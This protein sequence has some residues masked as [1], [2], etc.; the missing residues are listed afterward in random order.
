MS[1]ERARKN[2]LQAVEMLRTFLMRMNFDPKE[3]TF[4]EGS[5]FRMTMEGPTPT[6]I[7]RILAN[8]ERFT[9]H[10]YFD[11]KAAPELRMKVAEF[12]TRVN[13]GLISGSL[14]MSFSD[15]MLRYKSAIDF[16]GI[17]L[18]EILVRNAMLSAMENLETI[19]V[20][21]WDVLDGT[22]E[23]EAAAAIARGEAPAS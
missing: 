6:V 5:A 4:P 13:Y 1:S 2:G 12:I 19:A 15:G 8:K 7:A 16:T 3:E 22:L 9:L 14:E 17:E 23:P 21:L 18:P 11:R 10:Y 20:P